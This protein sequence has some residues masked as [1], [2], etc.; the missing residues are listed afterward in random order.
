ML[1]VISLTQFKYNLKNNT[2]K[3]TFNEVVKLKP[4]VDSPNCT[5]TI[6]KRIYN[7]NNY[8]YK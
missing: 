2:R 8:I 7:N 4:T 6:D 5:F 3:F 1:T